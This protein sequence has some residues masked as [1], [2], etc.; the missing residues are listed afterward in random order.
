VN[1]RER[2]QALQA[3][4]TAARAFVDVGERQRALDQINAALAIDPEF[5]AAQS[6]RERIL[7]GEF[8][9]PPAQQTDASVA[10]AFRVAVEDTGVAAPQRAAYE[11]GGALVPG[12]PLIS[13]EGFARF[14]ARAKRR[15]VDR[16]IEAAR[17]AMARGRVKDAAS[18]LEEIADLDPNLPEIHVLNAELTERRRLATRSHRGPWVTAAAVFATLV[19][20][21]SWVRESG[22]LPSRPITPLVELVTPPTT[23]LPVDPSDTDDLVA[24]AAP[25]EPQPAAEPEAAPVR[26]EP[27][28]RLASAA[29]D[30]TPPPTRPSS[31]IPQPE[32]AS[33]AP[34]VRNARLEPDATPDRGV[35]TPSSREATPEPALPETGRRIVDPPVA[36]AANTRA[37]APPALVADS[38]AVPAAVPATAVPSTSRADDEVLVKQTLQ[39]YRSAY[40]GLDARSAQAVWPA[41][42]QAALAR[43]FDGL[44][45]QSLTFERCDVQLRG[46][47]ANATCRGSARYV[48]KVGSR[49]PR[50]EPRVWSFALRKTGDDW[51]IESARAER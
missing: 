7:A 25:A 18:I 31:A 20:A 38:S 40:E 44:E 4:L 5:L 32:P 17:A 50:T 45:S 12:A 1:Q 9:A 8:L 6:L 37:S 47:T 35:R 29:V 46:E 22:S 11:S 28:R 27:V 51:K 24:D 42:N 15:R 14:E 48:P 26:V 41:V 43:A 13:T 2:W 49:E 21:A 19:L 30:V 39:R 10:A 34:P 36:S 23:Y 33:V 3:R 16:R